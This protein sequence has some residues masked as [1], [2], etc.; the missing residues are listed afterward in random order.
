VSDV[1]GTASAFLI[2]GLNGY[3]FKVNDAKAMANRMHLIINMTDQELHA[4]AV[5][6][7]ALSQR[8]TPETSAGNI[9]SVSN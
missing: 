3:N 7:H 4:M 1:V 6:S 2:S 8:I 5:S 9:L